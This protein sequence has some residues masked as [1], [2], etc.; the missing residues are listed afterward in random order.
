MVNNAKYFD[1]IKHVTCEM[2]M[3]LRISWFKTVIKDMQ[4]RNEYTT[5]KYFKSAVLR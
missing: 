5:S 1:T 4:S 3:Q 2:Q